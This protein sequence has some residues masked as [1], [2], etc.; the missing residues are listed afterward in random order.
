MGLDLKGSVKTKT[1]KPA[2]GRLLKGK[3]HSRTK[4]HGPDAGHLVE[5]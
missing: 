1:K 3:Q 5:W 2:D 4:K